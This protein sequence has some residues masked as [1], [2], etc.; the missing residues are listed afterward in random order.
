MIS[1]LRLLAFGLIGLLG[2][3]LA[4][5]VWLALTTGTANVHNQRIDR[6]TQ[7]LYYWL[8]VGVQVALAAVCLLRVANGLP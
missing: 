2:V 5:Q 1:A 4:R 6:N 7:P 3:W 8:A